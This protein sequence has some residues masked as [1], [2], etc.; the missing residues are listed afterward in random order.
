V[1]SVN[2]KT[3]G[4]QQ[5]EAQA[6]AL[7]SPAQKRKEGC[8]AQAGTCMIT[9]LSPHAQAGTCMIAILS[10]HAQAGTCMIKIPSLHAQ[11]C[12]QLS[13]MRKQGPV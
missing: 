9:I 2:C 6:S 1:V 7:R 13:R 10:P 11:G 5:P 4:A 3:Y 12:R 8:L